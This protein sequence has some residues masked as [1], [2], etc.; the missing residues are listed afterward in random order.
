MK[1]SPHTTEDHFGAV[2]ASRECIVEVASDR[3]ALR[4][5]LAEFGYRMVIEEGAFWETAW[6]EVVESARVRVF[7]K[8]AVEIDSKQGYIPPTV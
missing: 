4:E 1:N 5:A 2:S 8:L 6:R 7:T 3:M